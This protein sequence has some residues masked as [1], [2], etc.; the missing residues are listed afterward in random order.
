M[1]SV[2]WVLKYQV[3]DE[4]PTKILQLPLKEHKDVQL[5]VGG[6][7]SRLSATGRTDGARQQQTQ[8]RTFKFTLV[9]IIIIKFTMILESAD[10]Q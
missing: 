1:D 2:S 6:L 3:V 9:I 8:L 7:G 4:F 5:S 10:W